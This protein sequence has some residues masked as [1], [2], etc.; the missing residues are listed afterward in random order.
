MRWAASVKVR[1]WN[2]PG[3]PAETAPFPNRLQST[4][5]ARHE[6]TYKIA[7]IRMNNT[8]YRSVCCI[9]HD[10][11]LPMILLWHAG[12][13]SLYEGLLH[14]SAGSWDPSSSLLLCLLATGV[15][16]DSLFLFGCC[17]PVTSYQ[18]LDRLSVVLCPTRFRSLKSQHGSGSDH[19]EGSSSSR[20]RW[21]CPAGCFGS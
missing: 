18:L 4:R 6:S 1:K 11:T 20:G 15:Y 7:M 16:L 17:W 13:M 3:T 12:S 19:A 9:N 5:R 21:W 2:R 14:I 8:I 10:H